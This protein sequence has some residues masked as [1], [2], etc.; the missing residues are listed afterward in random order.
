MSNLRSLSLLSLAGLAAGCGAASV[1]SNSSQ[2]FNSDWQN[3]GGRSIAALEQRLHGLP[4]VP[5]ARVVVGLT[6]TGLS[7]ASLDGKSHWVHAGK[8]TSPPMIAGNLVIVAEG[9]QVVALDASSGSKV[10]SIG[11]RGLALRGAANDGT[12][13]VLVLAD[14]HKSLF[15]GVSASGSALGSAE[16]S[17]ALGVPAARGGIGFVPW[18]NQYV[19]ALDIKSGDESA[20]L[21]MREQVSHALNYGGQIYFGEKGLLRFD[22]KARFASTNQ[23]NHVTLPKLALP[24][25]PDWLGNGLLSPTSEANARSKIRIYAAPANAPSGE[26]TLG[27]GTF[28]ASYFHVVFGLDS[29]TGALS[30]VRA[31]P[32]DIVGGAAAPSG[33]VLCD[34][35]GKVWS[36]DSTGSSAGTLDL[37]SKVRL[38]TADAG[39]LPV[40][41]TPAHG[42]LSAQIAQA[43]D[44]LEPDMAEAERYLVSE[45]GKLED[46]LVTKTLIDLSSSPRIPPELRDETRRLLA[47]RKNGTDYMLAAL[48]RHYDFVSGVLLAP[49]VGPLADALAAS[50]ETRAAPLLAKH[51]NDPAN[52]ADD[53]AHAARALVKLATAAEYEDLRTFFALYRATADDEALVAA[54]VACAEAV[55]RVGGDAG[56]DVVERAAQDPLTQSDVR[57]ALPDVLAKF[58]AAGAAPSA[59]PAA[60]SAQNPAKAAGAQ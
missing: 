16:T 57:R 52:S 35:N 18:S 20:R 4:V 56:R 28:A 23:G 15:L 21:L 7:G 58:A 38:C 39:A 12:S 27:G 13:T 9:D 46:P 48:A 30:W 41:G 10:W 24:G 44:Q 26:L 60:A 32:A 42:A 33:F 55:L 29:K 36:L 45:L 17:V 49:P 37:G 50:N 34:A 40:T 31:M 3:D 53:V 1:N 51:L 43:L 54:V 25:K 59:T 6:D 47:L 8:E 14:T 5:N 19:S 22:E 11:N 2:S